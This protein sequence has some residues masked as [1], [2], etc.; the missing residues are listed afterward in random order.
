MGKYRST[1][2]YHNIGPCVFRQWR[3]DSHCK[4]LHGYAL[5]F[6]F[7][8]ESDTLDVRN[9]VMDF[10]GLKPLKQHLEE[11]YDHTCLMAEDDPLKPLFVEMHQAGLVQLVEVDNTGCEAT[12]DFLY[13]W[14]NEIFLPSYGSGEADRIWCSR[15]E[16][17]E[18][19]TNMAARVGTRE[20]HFKGKYAEIK[21][22]MA[23]P[24]K[25]LDHVVQSPVDK[26]EV[27]YLSDKIESYHGC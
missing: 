2:T 14:V 23:D 25:V 11:W 22:T 8:F 3:A 6:H 15:V 26:D 12:A 20:E 7:E 17:R 10:G 1:K 5:T 19:P 27:V 13:R 18:T 24:T 4:F 21:G 16:V 9:W